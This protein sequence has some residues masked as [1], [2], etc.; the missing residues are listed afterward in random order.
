MEKFVNFIPCHFAKHFKKFEK[1]IFETV[2]EF[3]CCIKNW[4]RVVSFRVDH[5]FSCSCLIIMEFEEFIGNSIFPKS[6]RFAF[7][8]HNLTKKL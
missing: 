8:A 2:V 3:S 1:K 5:Q 4:K 7:N 6:H